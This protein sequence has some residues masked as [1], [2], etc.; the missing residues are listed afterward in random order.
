MKKNEENS[1]RRNSMPAN[2]L[3]FLM[4]AGIVF[5]SCENTFID[6]TGNP[7]NTLDQTP[8]AD[9]F[10]ISGLT[11]IHDGRSKTVTITPKEGKS[12]G[13]ITIYY[14]GRVTAPSLLG[15]Y[16]V[17]F[18]IAPAP[19][20]NVAVGL[21][22]GTLAI[23]APVIN[24]PEYF[25]S[26]SALTSWLSTRSGGNELDDPIPV[27]VNI[28]LYSSISWN[29]LLTALDTAGKYVALD[30]STSTFSVFFNFNATRD[31]EGNPG[32]EKIV[33]LILPDTINTIGNGAFENFSNLT[34]II[35]P[36]S[37]TSM[38]YRVFWGCGNLTNITIPESVTRIM[39]GTFHGCSSLANIIIPDDT[40]SI[41]N[42]AFAY[43]TSLTNISIPDT[44]TSIETQ[45][46]FGCSSL[47]SII[48]P[49]GVPVIEPYTFIYC[50]NLADVSIPDS[51]TSIGQ[52][53][54][55]RCTSL[56]DISI[57][58]SVTSIGP[59]AFSYCTSLVSITIP[60]GVNNIADS[61]F[62][63]CNNLEAINVVSNNPAYSSEYGILFNKDKT[64]LLKCPSGKTDTVIIPVSV[65][66]MGYGAFEYCNKLTSIAIGN[67]VTSISDRAFFRCTGLTGVTIGNNV[68]SIGNE[69]FYLCIN[70][71][72]IT[73]PDNVETIGD[74]AFYSCV[75]L[76]TVT[77]KGEVTLSNNHTF[78]DN[79]FTE[80]L[81]GGP[82]T[83][84]RQD[85]RNA[86]W[87]K[88]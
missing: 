44:V 5:F 70:L 22:A 49:D 65:T 69:A 1:I 17:T 77:F 30:L 67:S 74:Y 9:D 13:A 43:C 21:A 20:W 31:T 10:I 15:T 23:N 51:V 56:A 59:S 76:I 55:E 39:G 34:S 87:T 35:I 16:P 36:D 47:V 8:S 33:S 83:Y 75:K 66:D 6:D 61:A 68:T 32:K 62:R 48:I 60:D 41:G 46:F 18:D 73:I 78:P 54:F 19:G 52:S 63:Y 71:T 72:G 4:F 11:Q 64:V 29:N 14:D 80:Y 81:A 86:T 45:A 37:V 57:P 12:T 53:A 50:A 2:V 40:T 42:S 3:I 24:D 28:H 82:G 85:G 26:I 79:L 88:N 38:G 27:K 7:D 84:T 58:D 25:T